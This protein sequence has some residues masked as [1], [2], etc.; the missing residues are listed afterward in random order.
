MGALVDHQVVGLGEPTLAVLAH[1]LAL[2]P[3]L[4]TEVGPTVVIVNSHHGE[5]FGSFFVFGGFNGVVFKC[6]WCG[7]GKWWLVLFKANKNKCSGC[8]VLIVYE[9]VFSENEC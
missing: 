8:D 9:L 3:H 2:W 5:H 1:E 6:W 7:D 4:A